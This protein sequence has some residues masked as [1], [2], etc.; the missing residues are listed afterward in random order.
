ML[1]VFFQPHPLLQNYVEAIIISNFDFDCE[2]NI[3]SISTFV[4]TYERFLCFHLA[5]QIQVKKE[6]SQYSLRP[7]SIIVGQQLKPVELNFGQIHFCVSAVLKPSGMFRLTGIPQHEMIDRD[8]DG[9]LLLGKEVNGLIEQLGNANSNNQKNIIIQQ[10]LLSKLWKLKPLLPFD[11]AISDLIN[12]GGNLSVEKLASLS[13]L[14][15]RQL[16]RISLERIGLSPKLYSRIIRFT[17]AYQYKEYFPKC[18]WTAIA[19]NCGYYD[20]M[21]MIHDFKFFAGINPGLLKENNIES[22]MHFQI[23]EA[24]ASFSEL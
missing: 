5:D 8:F 4:P 11:A 21:H 10:Y 17:R 2:R 6:N 23:S 22:L 12:S 19:H 15:V 16:E 18:S 13:C 14:C 7:R 24:E 3:S 9:S 20:Q 1:P